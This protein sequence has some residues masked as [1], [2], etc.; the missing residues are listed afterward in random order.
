MIKPSIE[1]FIVQGLVN[2][3]ERFA[4]EIGRLDFKAHEI[5][6][7]V[8]ITDGAS[9]GNSDADGSYVILEPSESTSLRGGPAPSQNGYFASGLVLDNN[10][11]LKAALYEIAARV[12]ALNADRDAK[13]YAALRHTYMEDA[14]DTQ[15]TIEYSCTC[16]LDGTTVVQICSVE[17]ETESMTETE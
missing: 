6:V 15:I 10:I 8:T 4:Y 16:Y 17:T 2:V 14:F 3:Q 7:L 12:F 9:D 13:V 1:Q 5:K 11:N